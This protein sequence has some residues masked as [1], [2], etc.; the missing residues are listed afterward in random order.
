LAS[1]I[2]IPFSSANSVASGVIL[3]SN[4][5]IEAN[6]FWTCSPARDF[7]AF[8]TSFLWTGPILMLVTGIFIV[9]K[10]SRRASKEP[11]VEAYTQTPWLV[12]STY[13]FIMS[14]ISPKTYAL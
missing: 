4:A 1:K 6:S 8:K 9:F 10:N 14:A 13:L 11:R 12:L 5:K 2:L 7:Y 3:T